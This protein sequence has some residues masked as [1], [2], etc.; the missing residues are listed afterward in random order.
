MC[1]GRGAARGSAGRA[2]LETAARQREGRRESGLVGPNEEAG[3]GDGRW[4]AQ[5]TA[6]LTP[7]QHQ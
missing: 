7:Q 1:V 3:K 5:G 6:W 2:E 4:V